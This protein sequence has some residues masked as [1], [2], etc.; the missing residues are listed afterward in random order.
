MI[1]TYKL[2]LLVFSLLY[3]ITNA[4]GQDVG[5]IIGQLVDTEKNEAIPFA[6]IRIRD[7]AVG[8]TSNV[9]G[10][11]KVPLEFKEIGEVLEISCL[12]YQTLLV[13]LST[14]MENEVNIVPLKP[15][16]FE[17]QE[18][19]VSAEIKKLSAK[20]I[21]KIAINSIPQNYPQN[22]FGLVGYYR[23]YQVKDKNYI[24]LSEALIKV[25]DK[26]FDVHDNFGNSYQLLS[27]GLNTDFVVD[28]FAKQPYDYERQ[29]KIVPSA[30]M[31]NDG[32]NEFITLSIHDAIRNYGLES[33]S[34]IND[35]RTDFVESHNFRLQRTT[36]YKS[37]QIY[38]I[39]F[40]FRNNDYRAEGTIHI[41]KDDYAIHKLNYYLYKRK[42]P[43]D[44][45]SAVNADERFSDGFNKMNGELLY[46]IQSEYARGQANK[47]FLSYISFYNKVLVQ[48]PAEFK[49]KFV[50]NL[51]D[52]SFKIQVNKVPAELDKI[53]TR[54]FKVSYRNDAVP[55]KEFWFQEDERTFIVCPHVGYERAEQLFKGLFLERDNLQVADVKYSYRDIKDSLGNKLDERKWEYIHQYREFFVQEAT[56]GHQLISEN[57]EMAKNLPLDSPKQPV[58]RDYLE[59]NY[60]MNTPLPTIQN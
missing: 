15:S 31:V 21:V 55:I 40:G 60:W 46:H 5:Y 26:G 38:E 53:R 44:R 19:V 23:D 12:G 54:D 24:N 50:I 8:V 39:I 6:T 2:V 11:F 30:K 48:R 43:G 35:L 56:L 34:F 20:Q 28:S 49:S 14:L 47:M 9:D 57:E 25:N 10:T 42:K 16:A 1:R 4:V 18:A 36:N 3:G 33:F 58:L 27:F 22:A 29:N 32:G 41:N 7:K 17:L 52:K 37:Q 51:E 13:E 59:G 45:S